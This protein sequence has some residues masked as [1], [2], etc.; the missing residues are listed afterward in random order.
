VTLDRIESV[1]TSLGAK[2]ACANAYALTKT[3]DIRCTRVTDRQALQACLQFL[4]DHRILVEPACGAALAALYV[5]G[6]EL[7]QS[8]KAPLVIVCGGVTATHAQIQTWLE[9]AVS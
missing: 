4:Q 5:Q 6:A 7:S 8:F 1:A 9:Q 3:H 2:Q